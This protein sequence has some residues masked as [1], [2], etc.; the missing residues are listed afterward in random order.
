MSKMMNTLILKDQEK[1]AE[2]RQET[3]REVRLSE[4]VDKALVVGTRL[5]R[6]LTIDKR[7][8][9]KRNERIADLVGKNN[10]LESLN[11]KNE[12]RM[13]LQLSRLVNI[14]E[15]AIDPKV[16][17]RDEETVLNPLDENF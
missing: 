14:L 17:E 10:E 6:R 9:A 13:C 2:E 1:M 5:K 15:S 16:L 7:M 3:A 4:M 8:I 11:R 12:A